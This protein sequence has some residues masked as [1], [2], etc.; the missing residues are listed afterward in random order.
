MNDKEICE[1]LNRKWWNRDDA[2]PMEELVLDALKEARQDERK[3]KPDCDDCP[4]AENNKELKLSEDF[5]TKEN[6]KLQAKIIKLEKEIAE[7]KKQIE[8]L[9]KLPYSDEPGLCCLIAV[10]AWK[11]RWEELKEFLNDENL[12]DDDSL[13]GI[14]DVLEEMK[15]LESG[16][17]VPSPKPNTVRLRKA[18]V[19]GDADIKELGT[20]KP[21]FKHME[22][23]LTRE[24]V[25]GRVSI[26]KKL[27]TFCG[28]CGQEVEIE[29][30]K[31]LK[32]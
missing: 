24:A 29:G 4:I 16:G 18:S 31:E 3:H 28:A 27:K 17:E 10:K 14:D 26:K 2:T 22:N 7:L 23:I 21:D 32:A 5:L 12:P 30:K 8:K 25:H 6:T 19:A 9:N 15:E 1:K 11:A 20:P 13:I